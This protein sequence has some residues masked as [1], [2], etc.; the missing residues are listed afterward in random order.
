MATFTVTIAGVD[1]TSLIPLE[2]F[3]A[4]IGARDAITTCSFDLRDE[5]K[6]IEIKG[7][8][9]VVV[10]KDG[11]SVWAGYV[12]NVS[13]AFDGSANV[14]SIDAQSGNCML[15]AKAFRYMGKISKG[16]AGSANDKGSIRYLTRS[17]GAEV[18]WLLASSTSSPGASAI[19]YN[20]AKINKQAT[21]YTD[22]RDY[23]GLTL[24]EAIKKF[25]KDAYGDKKMSFW[26][27]ASLELNIQ[28][29]G[30][31]SNLLE[32]FDLDVNPDTSWTL[33][34]SAAVSA[35]AGQ[36]T[37][38]ADA[39]YGISLGASTQSA[40]QSV[41]VTAE[42]R[43]YAS[44]SVKNTVADRGRISIVWYS[45]TPAIIS[46]TTLAASATPLSWTRL[47]EIVTA[48]ALATTARFSVT[49]VGSTSGSA[50]FDNLQ[51]IEESA[52][53]GISD[54]P[55]GTTTFAPENYEESSDS[56]GIINAIA[57]KGKEWTDPGS[58]LL[59]TEATKGNYTY[60][61]EYPVSIAYFQKKFTSAIADDQVNSP[62]KARNAARK[63]FA[64]SAFPIREGKYAISSTKLG[65]L[66]PSPGTYQIFQLSRMPSARQTTINR[67]ES[68]TILPFGAG[69]VVYEIQ[70]GAAKG[71]IAT[72]L[73]TLGSAIWGTGMPAIASTAF[74]HQ[75]ISD[76][77]IS[78]KRIL[79]DPST[80]GAAAEVTQ[81]ATVR[82]IAEIPVIQKN[83]SLAPTA[84]LPSLADYGGDGEFPL[85]S[86]I[87]LVPD[88]GDVH[89]M[90]KPTLYR[91]D[92]ATTWTAITAAQLKSDALNSGMM[93]NGIV[94]DAIFAGT[95]DASTISVT[96]L[97]ATN[98]KS[99]SLTISPTVGAGASAITSTNFNVSS[100]GIVSAAGGVFDPITTASAQRAALTVKGNSTEGDIATTASTNITLGYRT[101]A[102][103]IGG[104]FYPILRVRNPASGAEGTVDVYGGMTVT[105]A[106]QSTNGL[107]GDNVLQ[108]Y[109]TGDSNNRF[110]LE[111]DGVMS[112]GSG[113]AAVDTNLYRNAANALKTDDSLTVAGFLSVEGN[114][115][116]GNS[117][118]ADSVQM[119]LPT[120][121]TTSNS[122]PLRIATSTSH[123]LGLLYQVFRDSSSSLKYKTD[124]AD[125]PDSLAILDAT[126][127]TYLDKASI[128][129]PNAIRQVGF[130]AEQMATVPELSVYVGMG[131]DG[132]PDN[133]DYGKLVVPI[134][135]ALRAQQKRIVKLEE[136]LAALETDDTIA[137]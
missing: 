84:N 20:S 54:A 52:A 14:F 26:V 105:D 75:T 130:I 25:C 15:D 125:L 118:T 99:G 77:A 32:N 133:I 18:T 17:F 56:T 106:I 58:P 13:T 90:G 113:A 4:E 66:V 44:G 91:S 89:G 70:F 93:K 51:M 45:A 1:R 42:K 63:I 78:V 116:L 59:L 12:G 96:N 119:Y 47:E 101:G 57:I 95:I 21:T 41:T 67:I 110:K 135:S 62:T 121:A 79:T 38:I 49:Y 33:V 85:G 7:N 129:D 68:V 37:G 6:A 55:N 50:Y 10:Q 5:T 16:T 9:T 36:A 123:P 132:K 69:E 65:S 94:A 127:V 73:A 111:Q 8:S 83:A 27:D 24:R 29:T 28:P 107:S 108:T 103:A 128:G 72:S 112:W 81:G 60:Y 31:A 104:S 61:V 124:V 39:D 126:P 71:S 76:A 87:L 34:G 131:E 48:P 22:R 109:V 19:V 40:Y 86:L 30:Q 120:S 122:Q 46:T 114:T 53:F 97:S 100:S 82:G 137:K 117:T 64:E 88:S 11:V 74:E 43:Y 98:I 80:T 134:I 136:R 115:L 102:S 2:S 92:G 23:G 35:A 3:T